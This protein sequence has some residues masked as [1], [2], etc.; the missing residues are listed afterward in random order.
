MELVGAGG[1]VVVTIPDYTVTPQ[2]A[3]FGDRQQQSAAIHESNEIMTELASGLGI[4]V[5]DIHDISLEAATDR[6]LVAGDGL[7]PSGI[8]YTRWVD[9]I[10]PALEA[11]L[12]R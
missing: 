9:R 1:I 4:T 11:T 12:A 3:A 8:Q 6:S 10:A 7:H 2:G 5:V